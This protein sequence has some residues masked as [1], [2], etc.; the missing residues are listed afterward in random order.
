MKRVPAWYMECKL[1]GQMQRSSYTAHWVIC[2]TCTNEMVPWEDTLPKTILR[3]R[4]KSSQKPQGWHFMNEYIDKDGNVYHKGKEQ[5]ELKGTLKPTIIIKKKRLTKKEK[6]QIKQ[7]ISR[8]IYELKQKL[9][10]AKWKK[11][12]II[13]ERKIKKKQRGLK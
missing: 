11:D 7:D 9:K 2:S 8:E 10:K 1:C 12:K 4:D 3:Q 6:Q 5:P 13:I